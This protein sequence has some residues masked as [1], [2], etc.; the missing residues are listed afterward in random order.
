MLGSALVIRSK[1]CYERRIRIPLDPHET[2]R[3][4]EILALPGWKVIDTPFSA[5]VDQFQAQG[6]E[7]V[8][9][10]ESTDVWWVAIAAL[11]LKG[12]AMMDGKHV[13]AINFELADSDIIP[14]REALE[15]AA[16][17]LSWELHEDDLDDSDH[18]DE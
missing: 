18:D 2:R 4:P 14:A 6:L 7:A 8:A 13:E 9:T 11:Q 17:A 10:R 12:Y 15:Q 5:W 3:M 16:S 1:L